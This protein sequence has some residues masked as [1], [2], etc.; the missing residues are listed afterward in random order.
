MRV[1][2]FM[3]NAGVVIDFA[4]FYEHKLH[5]KEWERQFDPDVRGA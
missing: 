2:F 5:E 3:R 4:G 1:K